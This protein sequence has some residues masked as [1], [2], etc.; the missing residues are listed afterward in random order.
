MVRHLQ[1]AK[2]FATEKEKVS[3]IYERNIHFATRVRDRR[4]KPEARG[5]CVDGLRADSPTRPCMNFSHKGGARPINHL[6]HTV[7]AIKYS[8]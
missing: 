2:P 8:R 5:M 6:H 4:G 7:K 1:R 3:V